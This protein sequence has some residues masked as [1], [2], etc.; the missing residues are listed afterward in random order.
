L[1]SSTGLF[2]R[3]ELSKSSLS[4]W[5]DETPLV[6]LRI[7]I[8]RVIHSSQRGTYLAHVDLCFKVVFIVVLVFVLLFLT[9][10]VFFLFFFL[11]A[12]LFEKEIK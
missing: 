4:A 7:T 12:L 3:D 6:G 8:S 2:F 5:R 10:V 11:S 1:A 9:L